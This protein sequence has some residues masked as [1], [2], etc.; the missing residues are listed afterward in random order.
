MEM[1]QKFY[2]PLYWDILKSAHSFF[3]GKGFEKTTGTDVCDN[4]D[5]NTS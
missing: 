1:H 4:L 5:I 2:Q 3:L